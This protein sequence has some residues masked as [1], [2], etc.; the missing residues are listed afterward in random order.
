MTRYKK[1]YHHSRKIS[2]S[3]QETLAHEIARVQELRHELENGLARF[4]QLLDNANV[5]LDGLS[6][7]NRES[8]N[9]NRI[10]ME[11]VDQL[12]HKILAD[13]NYNIGYLPDWVEEKLYRNIFRMIFA[14][15]DVT[16]AETTLNIPGHQIRMYITPQDKLDPSF[17]KN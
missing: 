14:L 4:H 3:Q 8:L 6:Q 1:H 7:K 13:P 15:L 9:T 2:E 16:V 10:S 17:L 11:I 12:V 5:Q